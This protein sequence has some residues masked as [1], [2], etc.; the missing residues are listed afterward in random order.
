[1]TTGT[2]RTLEMIRA[3]RDACA[4]KWARRML[5]AGLAGW[6]LE[7]DAFA[8][9]V[10]VDPPTH[11]A[12]VTGFQVACIVVMCVSCGVGMLALLVSIVG[13]VRKGTRG[14]YLTPFIVNVLGWVS[15]A[16]FG[17]IWGELVFKR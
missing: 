7:L 2:A 5:Y 15:N 1:M 8:M 3:D 14:A 4:R 12:E 6:G 9:M 13:L 17:I 11:G 10:L 16:A